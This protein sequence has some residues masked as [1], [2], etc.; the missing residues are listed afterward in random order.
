MRN[1]ALSAACTACLAACAATTP[2]TGEMADGEGAHL[3]PP[4]DSPVMRAA[5]PAQAR[6]QL[7]QP[8]LGGAPVMGIP[9]GGNLFQPVSGGAPVAGMNLNP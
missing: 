5:P 2:S 4:V 7:F 9:L 6:P 1:L 8:I 3:L